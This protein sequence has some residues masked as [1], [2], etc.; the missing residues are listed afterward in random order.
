MPPTIF[1]PEFAVSFFTT[2]MVAKRREGDGWLHEIK[3]DGHRLVAILDGRAQ[4]GNNA[5][6]DHDVDGDPR[7]AA[8]TTRFDIGAD[9]LP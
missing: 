9:E 7:P 4:A 3:H 5:G 6:V 2:A 1:D 8:G